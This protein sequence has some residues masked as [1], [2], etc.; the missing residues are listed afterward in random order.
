MKYRP[1]FPDRFGCIEDARPHS[2]AFFAC[3]NDQHCHSA[4]GY[5]TPNDMFGWRQQEIH[6]E[7]RASP[8]E[9]TSQRFKSAAH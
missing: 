2:Q 1:E 9:L 4:I 8:K 6:A 7:S 3:Y 5:M